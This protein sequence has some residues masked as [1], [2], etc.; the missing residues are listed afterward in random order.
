M[1]EAPGC[2]AP[3]GSRRGQVAEWS[4]SGLQSRVRRFDS[5]P[6]LQSLPAGSGI[7]AAT[8]SSLARPS[9]A[10]LRVGPP[11]PSARRPSQPTSPRR[12]GHPC[13][14]RLLARSAKPRFAPRR[15]SVALRAPAL[16][17]DLSP[18]DR[19]SRPRPAPRS[20][21]QA[22][23]RSAS[24][25]RRPPRAGPPSRPLP[26][27]SGISAATGSSLARPSLASLR[28]GPPSPSPRAGPPSRP[29]SPRR[30]GHP[31]RDRLLA[32]SAKPRFAPRRASVALSARR[33]SQP[34]S[35]RRIG[36][37]GG[38]R[39][40]WRSEASADRAR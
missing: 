36:H 40:R 18:P 20:L 26:A 11:S 32:R 27:G 35:P 37:P 19:A 38:E 22:S 12:I 21:G 5:D 23:L 4:C 2:V 24:G 17:A 39:A 7:P 10:S 34:A 25:L 9:L 3:P 28:V 15:A 14:D 6:G 31:C 13:R 30:I 1:R 33:P 29:L 8:V 16:P